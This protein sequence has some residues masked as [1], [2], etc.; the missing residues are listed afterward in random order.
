MNRFDLVE[1]LEL[2]DFN[3]FKPEFNLLDP[4]TLPKPNLERL[5]TNPLFFQP[6]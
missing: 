1:K 4:N 3:L 5:Y 2:N 6:I